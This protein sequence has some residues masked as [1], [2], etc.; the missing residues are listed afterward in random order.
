MLVILLTTRKYFAMDG[1]KKR[2][3]TS[4]VHVL[5]KDY[6]K[7]KVWYVCSVFIVLCSP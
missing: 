3:S 4:A 5:K 7:G 1:E 6:V 2:G